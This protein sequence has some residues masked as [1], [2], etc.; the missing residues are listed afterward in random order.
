METTQHI[1]AYFLHDTNTFFNKDQLLS[2]KNKR[3][4]LTKDELFLFLYVDDGA[5]IYSTRRE[6]KLGTE[7]CFEQMKRL[8]LN[9]HTED[10]KKPS[11]LDRKSNPE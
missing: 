1:H 3:R 11:N 7:I 8:G 4:F 5:L 6:A 2:H 9:I 10:W